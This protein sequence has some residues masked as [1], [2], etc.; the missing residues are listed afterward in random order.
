[1]IDLPNYEVIS[2]SSASESVSDTEYDSLDFDYC[3]PLTMVASFIGIDGFATHAVNNK[4][5]ELIKGE[6]FGYSIIESSSRVDRENE[7]F[8]IV[9]L[10]CDNVHIF[11][12]DSIDSHQLTNDEILQLGSCEYALVR[13]VFNDTDGDYV[14]Y[15]ISDKRTAA[16]LASGS[17]IYFLYNFGRTVFDR[18]ISMSSL[19]NFSFNGFTFFS[20]V[21]D[22]FLIYVG[23]CVIKWAIP[24]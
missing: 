17:D 23:W 20:L 24:T 15:R 6:K 11:T 16:A 1:M 12:L 18:V 22:S 2:Y 19:L 14:W 13:N 9:P 7:D 8:D 21:T 4:H 3:Y 5:N 10:C